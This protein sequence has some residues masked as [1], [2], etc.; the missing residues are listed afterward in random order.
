M[1]GAVPGPWREGAAGAT[2]PSRRSLCAQQLTVR[3]CRSAGPLHVSTAPPGGWKEAFDLAG[4][5]ASSLGECPICFECMHGSRR[6]SSESARLSLDSELPRSAALVAPSMPPA[7]YPAGVAQ[8]SP[9]EVQAQSSSSAG[10]SELSGPRH[11]SAPVQAEHEVGAGACGGCSSSS[12]DDA[13]CSGCTP[14]QPGNAATEEAG[15]KVL[16]TAEAATP[17]VS[18]GNVFVTEAMRS[19]TSSGSASDDDDSD[20]NATLARECHIVHS[21]DA[22]TPA[23]ERAAAGAAPPPPQRLP[24][25]MSS[26]V[27]LAGLDM[28]AASERGAG[29][30]GVAWE[31]AAASCTGG[32]AAEGAPRPAAPP[33]WLKEDLVVTDCGHVF[34]SVCLLR[35]EQSLA[36]R[37]GTSAAPSP[38]CPVC[39]R[40]Y[41]RYLGAMGA[42]FA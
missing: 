35:H 12:T 21:L 14:G 9:L 17:T 16:P 23:R 18:A 7:P 27:P 31:A 36:A 42:T 33:E 3:F 24:A 6:S 25:S 38:Q 30:G 8:E 41:R 10:A 5:R 22:D 37:A 32:C 19:A 20:V 28:P 4:G 1:C 34:H 40:V 15:G 13:P 29:E 11:D 26:P 39:R 2:L